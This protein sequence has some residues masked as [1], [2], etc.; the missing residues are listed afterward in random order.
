M[1]C[2]Y[3][4]VRAFLPVIA[5]AANVTEIYGICLAENKVAENKGQFSY[6]NNSEK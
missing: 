4:A 2:T 5:K 3:E 6:F 1:V